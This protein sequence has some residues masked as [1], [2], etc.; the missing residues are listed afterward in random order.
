MAQPPSAAQATLLASPDDTEAQFYE[1]MQ[2]GDI[3]KLMGVWADDDEVVCVHPGGARV[4]GL[5]AI[6]AS[7]EAIFAQNAVPVQPE[8]VHRLHTMACAVHHLAERVS[9]LTAEGPQTAWALATNV[10][11]KTA[12]GWR[13]VA[14]HASPGQLGEPPPTLQELPSTLH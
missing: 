8:Q 5:A 6:R 1:A 7:F 9:V 4:V 12:Q 14:H 11:V 10:Y 2:S 13:M 3:D